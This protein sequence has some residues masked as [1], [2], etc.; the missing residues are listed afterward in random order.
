MSAVPPDEPCDDCQC[1]GQVKSV[2]CFE[3]APE[4]RGKG[5]ATLL[6]EAVCEDAMAEGY[7]YVEAYPV[8]EE[9]LQGMAFTG[10]KRLYEKA[11]FMVDARDGS[12][13][14]M[15]KKLDRIIAACGNEHDSAAHEDL[16]DD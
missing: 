6:L 15:R 8:K 16:P 3:I 2:V 9:G 11:G 5:I 1:R 12:T 4:Y 14:V 7:V 10:P 13:L